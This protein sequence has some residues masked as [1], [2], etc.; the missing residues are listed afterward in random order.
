MTAEESKLIEQYADS[1]VNALALKLRDSDDVDSKFVLRQIAGRQIMRRKMPLW[2]SNRDVQYPDHLP[3]E[4]C[5]SFFTAQYKKEIGERL[6]SSFDNCA[7]LTGGFGVDFFVMSENFSHAVYAER[8][9]DL[10]DVVRHNFEVLHRSNAEFLNSDGVDFIKNTTQRFNLVFID[11][12]RRNSAGKKT[13]RIEDC[14]P[15][16]LLFQDVM[17]QKA[18]VVMIKLS[19]MIDIADITTKLHNV[20]EIHLVATANECKEVLVLLQNGYN[21]EPK[22]FTVNDNQ[23]YTFILSNERECAANFFQSSD[24]RGKYLFEPNAAVMKSGA[25]K[26]LT[27]DYNVCKLQASSHLYIADNDVKDFPG[28]RFKIVRAGQPKEFSGMGTANLAVRN[29]PEKA[30]I[31]KKKLKIRDGGNIFL[32]ATTLYNGSKALIQCNKVE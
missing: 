3:L 19:P 31:L 5:S 7:D 20:S 15:D 12:A 4:Q 10:Y 14:E 21:S 1:D 25:F 26:I 13:V 24:L 16:I 22:I 27:K 29:F 32:F 9:T 17:I 18:D 8:N 11:P 30:E 6:L 23:R 2:A 28:R